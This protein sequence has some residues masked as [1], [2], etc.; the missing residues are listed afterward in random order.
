MTIDGA[1]R[2]IQGKYGVTARASVEYAQEQVRPDERVFA[3]FTANIYTHHGHFPGVAALT[4]Q[5][6]FAVCGLPGIRR[7][8]EYPLEALT[9][10]RDSKSPLTY[11]VSFG[12]DRDSFQ[13]ALSTQAGENFA[14]YAADLKQMIAMRGNR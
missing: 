8:V 14:P 3:A 7:L 10:C 13:A 1:I 4:D 6:V 12:T 5:R 9:M 11:K 2:K